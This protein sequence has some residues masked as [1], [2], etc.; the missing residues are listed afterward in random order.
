VHIQKLIA[1]E[2][3]LPP[4]QSLHLRDVLRLRT[5]DWVEAFDDAGASADAEIVAANVSQVTL[6]ITSIRPPPFA[7]ATWTIACAVPKGPRADWLVEKLSELGAAAFIPLITQRSVAAPQ[8]AGKFARW[9]RLASE[10]ARQSSRSGV[11]RIASLTPLADAIA[12]LDS[13]SAWYFSTAPDATPIAQLTARPPPSALT[14]FIGPE[15][16]WAEAEIEM[17]KSANFTPVRLT[18]TT[19]RIE[20]AALA[21]AAIAATW[22]EGGEWGGGDDKMFSGL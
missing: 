1:G 3:R 10:A 8:G 13:Q 11:M 7:S 22:F 16:G 9:N 15:G 6:S 12:A 14:M 18:S 17:F 19:L 5:G 4:A 20:T 2:V 21:A